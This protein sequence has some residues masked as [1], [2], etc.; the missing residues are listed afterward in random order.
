MPIKPVTQKAGFH[1]LK[2]LSACEVQAFLDVRLDSV[3]QRW[4]ARA[5]EIMQRPVVIPYLVFAAGVVFV[6]GRLFSVR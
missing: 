1:L 2:Q 6:V 4:T 3:S 5:A